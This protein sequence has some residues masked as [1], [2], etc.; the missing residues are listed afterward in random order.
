MMR[1]QAKAS[2]GVAEKLKECRFFLGKIER[3]CHH[4][5]SEDD[6]FL[7]YVSAFLSAFQTAINRAL[8]IV[9]I[10][11]G[12]TT[13]DRLS[14]QLRAS[15]DI[16]FLRATRNLE[17]HG[18]GP[19]IYNIDVWVRAT[20]GRFQS[21]SDRE[22]RRV[23]SHISSWQFEAHPKNLIRLYDDSLEELESIL[24]KFLPVRTASLQLE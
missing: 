20:S 5:G 7:C 1:N 24:T 21:R 6:A 11:G 8:D 10:T 15:N 9:E 12:P 22:S 23:L 18:D 2:E 16:A 13:K 14:A 4:N 3:V 17:V 19:K